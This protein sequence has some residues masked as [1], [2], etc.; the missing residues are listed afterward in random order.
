LLSIVEQG[1]VRV[2]RVEERP[3]D[4]VRLSYRDEVG[5]DHVVGLD[6]ARHVAF[7]RCRMARGIPSHRGQAHTPGRYWSATMGDLVEYESYL[8]CKC[9][10]LLD[11]DV[12]VVEFASQPMVIDGVDGQGSWRHVPDVFAR[13]ADGSAWLLDV[14]NPERLERPEVR[15]QA[16][17]TARVCARLGCDYQ[18]VGEPAAQRG[19]NVSWLSGYRRPVHLG[20]ELMPRLVDLARRPVAIGDLLGFMEYP[21]VARAVLFHLCWRQMIVFDLDAPLRETTLVVAQAGAR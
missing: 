14:K 12:D 8:E 9:F 4:L 6:Q 10:M 16:E 21:D 7:E 17:R 1:L 18:M 15:L 5:A 2:V 20:A 19:A 11:F 3:V 13:R